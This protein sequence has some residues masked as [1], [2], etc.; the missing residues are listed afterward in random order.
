[1]AKLFADHEDL[2]EEFSQFLPEAVPAAQAH[3]ER[4]R[5][6][7]EARKSVRGQWL[8]RCLC[9]VTKAVVQRGRREGGERKKRSNGGDMTEHGLATEELAFF[10]KVGGWGWMKGFSTSES[11]SKSP[12]VPR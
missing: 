1:M 11:L 8:C 12:S 3:A 10:E 7:R 9:V 5:K 6:A 4:Q 2:L